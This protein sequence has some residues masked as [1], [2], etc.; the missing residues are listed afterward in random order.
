M[1]GRFVADGDNIGLEAQ[2]AVADAF[3]V[4]IGDDRGHSPFGQTKA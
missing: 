4:W 1:T 3:V 2:G